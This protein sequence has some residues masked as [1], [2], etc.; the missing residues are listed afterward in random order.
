MSFSDFSLDLSDSCFDRLSTIIIHKF[1]AEGN[2]S[3]HH[4]VFDFIW[5]PE[6]IDL[7][8]FLMD[9]KVNFRVQHILKPFCQ[10]IWFHDVTFVRRILPNLQ[11]ALTNKTEKIEGAVSFFLFGYLWVFENAYDSNY[12]VGNSLKHELGFRFLSLK[13]F[14]L[15][16]LIM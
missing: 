13:L 6:L 3:F 11:I 14:N 9:M 7:A 15:P 4:S 5:Q 8:I 12:L 1:V 10:I 2:H 16:Q